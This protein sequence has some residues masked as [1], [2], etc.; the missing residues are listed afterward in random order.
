[1]TDNPIPVL[2]ITG[3]AGVGKST[4]SWL[5][6]TELARAG[7]RVAFADADQL[8]MCYPAPAADP[9]REQLKA[10]NVSA[11]V[12]RYRAAGAQCVI[13]NGVLDPLRG[14]H[15]ELMPQAEVTV[16]RLR[17]DREELAQRF[18][19]RGGQSDDLTDV[20]AE[21]L[22]EADAMDASLGADVCIETTGVP[23]GE[24]AK[25]V[26]NGCRGWP[27]FVVAQ[28]TVG[29]P[30]AVPREPGYAPI[31][32]TAADRADGNI[33]LICGATGVGKSTAGFQLYL[34]YLRA[35]LMAGYIDLDQL[36]F[37]R[38]E[39]DVDP[40]RHQLKAG[41]LAAM[42]L[43]YHAA[44]ARHLIATG[45]VESDAMLQTYLR[46]LPAAKVTVCRLHAGA[47]DLTLR[48]MSRGE[49]GSW[50]QPGDPL[51]GQPAEYLRQAADQAVAD[52]NTLERADVGAI[53]ICTDGRTVAEV[54]D[55]LA[56]ATGWS[57]SA[58][59]PAR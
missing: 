57:P 6:F 5:T 36:G 37:V 10:K 49:G 40:G 39:P 4:V 50:P 20:L 8:C 28:P 42:W 29:L 18:V 7:A 13:V 34:R 58:V 3:P 11:L 45:P 26:R 44:G 48:I 32:S 12:P 2:W 19:G 27:G 46:A 31:A 15:T 22:D 33:L 16:C 24:V 56:A 30:S 17:A 41:N 35:G 51:R 38:P 9:G 14:L 59:C 43:N 21:N 1:V 52:A 47:A 53:R 55:L 54:A 23:A 25:L